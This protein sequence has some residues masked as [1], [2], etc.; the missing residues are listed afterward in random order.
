MADHSLTDA[1]HDLIP[2]LRD[3]ARHPVVGSDL[4]I[5]ASVL[6]ERLEVLISGPPAERPKVA[7]GIAVYCFICGSISDDHWLGC[8]KGTAAL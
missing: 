4:R 3:F 2:R 7:S 5:Q 1:A 8:P 6:A